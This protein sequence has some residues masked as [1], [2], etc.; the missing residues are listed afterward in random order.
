MTV[1][2]EKKLCYDAISTQIA[3]EDDLAGKRL[4]WIITINGFLFAALGF[5]AGG[6]KPDPAI[7][8]LFKFVLPVTG[9]AISV[10]GFFG[11]VAAYIQIHYLTKQWEILNDCRWPRPFGDKRHSFL[12]G[13]IPSMFP[14]IVLLIVWIG[15]LAV[16][17]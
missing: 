1:P 13:I 12:L 17:H 15:L 5:L 7:L 3:R 8:S 2:D 11:V 6:V 10:A 9:I 4:T 14:P 16:W